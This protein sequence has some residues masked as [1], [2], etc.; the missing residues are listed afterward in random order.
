MTEPVATGEFL[1]H[2]TEPGERWDTLAA[3]YYGDAD[4]SDLLITANRDQFLKEVKPIPS[5]LPAGL[6]L[7][8]P[9]IEQETIDE[10][11][12]PPW[13]RGQSA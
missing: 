6:I 7:T 13:K 1:E 5:V 9:V 4:L 11:L 8:I 12:L 3:K 10:S 2:T